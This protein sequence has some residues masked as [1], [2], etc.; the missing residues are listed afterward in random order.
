MSRC[1][2]LSELPAPPAGKTGWPWTVE[3]PRYPDTLPDG[4]AW[5]RVSIVTPSFNQGAFIEET[6]RSVL[7]QG[8]PDLEYIVM[9]GGSTDN[10][11]E[12]LQRYAPWLSHWVSRKD[13]GQSQAINAGLARST[14]SIVAWMNSDDLYA[15]DAI[16]FAA[17]FMV[18]AQLEWLAGAAYVGTSWDDPHLRL[19]PK[20]R[21][22]RELLWGATFMQPS[23]FFG[24]ELWVDS[25]GV[26]ENLHFV[27]DYD[28]WC[29]F[30]ECGRFPVVVPRVLSLARKH[31]AMKNREANVP[32]VLAEKGRVI[33]R[34]AGFWRWLWWRWRPVALRLYGRPPPRTPRLPL[35]QEGE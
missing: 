25:R 12:V 11:V 14:G 23:S 29:R 31:G 13:G 34:H 35:P 5:P 22:R 28:L 1:P 26:D 10:T 4:S 15:P 24:R 7:L 20:N 30:E 17:S 9:D 27:M 6:L 21:S 8:Y 3:T 32:R 33:R 18:A 19:V 2:Q 16:G